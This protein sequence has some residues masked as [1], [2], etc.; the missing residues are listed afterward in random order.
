MYFFIAAYESKF[1]PQE[2][3]QKQLLDKLH[4][5]MTVLLAKLEE[6]TKKNGYIAINR[7]GNNNNLYFILFN[8]F[9]DYR[10]LGQI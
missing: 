3:R 7:V 4:G 2:E 10:F 1:E 8:D 9:I 5:Q 6:D